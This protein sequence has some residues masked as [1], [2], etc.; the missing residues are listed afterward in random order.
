MQVFRILILAT[1]VYCVA[2]MFTSAITAARRFQNSTGPLR[3]CRYQRRSV[4]ALILTAVWRG[5]GRDAGG[6]DGPSDTE[7][8]GCDYCCLRHE[9]RLSR[10]L[11]PAITGKA[12]YEIHEPPERRSVTSVDAIKTIQAWRE[13][14]AITVGDLRFV[15]A[16]PVSSWDTG[17][18]RNVGTPM[19]SRRI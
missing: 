9:F 6:G 7:R 14:S 2:C 10:C 12:L 4:R 17:S 15:A 16:R 8:R 3:L 13:N 1:A 11:H 5:R 19:F 18:R